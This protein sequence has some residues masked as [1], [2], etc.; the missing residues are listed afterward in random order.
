[1]SV[2]GPAVAAGEVSDEIRALAGAL[3]KAD[4]R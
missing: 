4:R 3:R 1:M 2:R